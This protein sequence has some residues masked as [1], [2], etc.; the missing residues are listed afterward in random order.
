VINNN[1]QKKKEVAMKKSEKRLLFW[2]PRILCILFAV[3]IS[4]FALDVF[5]EGYGFWKTI[6]ALLIHLIPTW[7]IVIVLVVSWHREWVAAILFN[8]LAA[9]YIVWYW[10]KFPW[11]N[12]LALSGPLFLVGVLFLINWVYRTE[13]RTR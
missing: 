5:E 6:L 2:A 11:V 9:L 1:I 8:A 10:G 12:Y 3:F 13:L 4:I 7:I